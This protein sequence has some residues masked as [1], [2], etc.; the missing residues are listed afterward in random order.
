MLSGWTCT[1]ARVFGGGGGGGG[2][3]QVCG[4]MCVR[5]EIEQVLWCVR[6]EME[7]VLWCSSLHNSYVHVFLFL[8]SVQGL[9]NP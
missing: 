2:G 5:G 9:L 8:F 7:Q 1:L 6:G 4:C 3:G